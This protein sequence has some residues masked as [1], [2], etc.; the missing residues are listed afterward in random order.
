V[1]EVYI[2][3]VQ[4]V[5]DAFAGIDPRGVLLRFDYDPIA[6]AAVKA[7]L[8]RARDAGLRMPGTWVPG[9]KAWVVTWEAWPDVRASLRAAGCPLVPGMPPAGNH[10]EEG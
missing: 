3:R 10:T 5:G 7:G 1:V 4:S 8:Q 9:L 6:V 2:E